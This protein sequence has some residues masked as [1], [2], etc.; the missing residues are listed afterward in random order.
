MDL[1]LIDLTLGEVLGALLVIAIVIAI[2]FQ[3]YRK[4]SRAD[5]AITAPDVP[6]SVIIAVKDAEAYSYSEASL[7]RR[8]VEYSQDIMAFLFPRLTYRFDF[9]VGRYRI[10]ASTIE[11]IV[12][13]AQNNGFLTLYGERDTTLRYLLPYFSE[14][15]VLN[16]WQI[17]TILEYLRRDHPGLRA[18]E[19]AEIESDPQLVAKVYSGYMGAGGDWDTWRADLKPGA[20]ARH[21][22]KL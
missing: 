7:P 18:L 15:P 14:I 4:L 8:A 20:V 1:N 9:S 2:F 11:S 5:F 19:W 22:M 6:R 17:S 3:R 13:W 16:D 12:E 10:K 21:R